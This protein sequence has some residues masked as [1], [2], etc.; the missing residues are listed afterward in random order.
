[1]TVIVSQIVSSVFN[2][3]CDKFR[4]HNQ[5]IATIQIN[6]CYWTPPNM[7][8]MRNINS[9]SILTILRV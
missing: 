1:M 4:C 2:Q 5:T 6:K 8:T 7:E 3:K 9:G